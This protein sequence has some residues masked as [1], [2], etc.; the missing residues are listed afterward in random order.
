[1]TLLHLP[2]DDDNMT[3]RK[4]KEEYVYLR[5]FMGGVY[6]RVCLFVGFIVIPSLASLTYVNSIT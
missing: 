5:R 2:D 4:K 1:M 3:I 6:V